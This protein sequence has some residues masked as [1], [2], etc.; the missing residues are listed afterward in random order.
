LLDDRA[1]APG[2][3]V[4]AH[5]HQYAQRAVAY[6]GGGAAE[7]AG[8]P[9]A[10]H[11]MHQIG[12]A[13]HRAALVALQAAHEVP[14]HCHPLA[15]HLGRL[16]RRLLV[17][18]LPDVAYAQR[19]EVDHVGGGEGL[20]HRDQRQ[21]RR[22]AAGGRAGGVDPRPQPLQVA[23][24]FGP[25]R[26]DR[27]GGQEPVLRKSGTSTS[28]KSTRRDGWLGG[29]EPPGPAGVTGRSGG[30]GGIG[31]RSSAG[32]YAGVPPSKPAA[33][34]VT[35]TSSPSES[36]I[37]APKMLL[38]SVWAASVPSC[39]AASIS[40]RPRSEP[41][42]MDSST[43]RAPSMLCSSSGLEMADSAA[44]TDR[45]SPRALPMPIRALPAPLITLLTSAKSR[46]IR[47]G[48]VIRSV[49]PCTPESSTWS[50]C[51]NASI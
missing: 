2:R 1:P 8:E 14:A 22:I 21:L 15:G 4:Q 47:P 49:M 38:A 40:I 18:V 6:L 37:T 10:V 13:R 45:L 41:P 29:V 28:S 51:R 11:R 12:V 46:L 32:L 3:P 27:A 42:A 20:G 43:P 30:A 24:Q 9:D 35:R 34:T 44:S 25:A 26:G 23:G 39:A 19:G 7:R 33:I 36:S 31:R 48:V 5:L 16:G 17:A 50:A